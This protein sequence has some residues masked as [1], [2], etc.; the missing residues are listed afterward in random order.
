MAT[1]DSVAAF[2]SLLQRKAL[3]GAVLVADYATAAL[4]DICTSGGTLDAL[5]GYSSLGKLTSDGLTLSNS[6]E[7]QESRGWGD[8]A[9]PSRNDITSASS[10]M[11]FSAMESNAPVIDAFWGVDQTAVT[12][13][14]T[15]GSVVFDL[16]PLPVL[17]NKRVLGLFRDTNQSN[18]L[19][20][21][22]GVHYP[23]ANISQNG[24]QTL[25]NNDLTYP[26][27]AQ[28]LVDDVEGTPVRLMWGG[29][30]L[31]GVLADMGYTVAA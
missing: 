18:G 10:S 28:A 9:S 24:D 5:T 29:P 23:R 21:Y 11:A 16:P 30:G 27:T 26:M 31:A 14:A 12:A 13:S 25:V 22:L 4:T 3:V 17:R 1:F 6:Q 2:Q 15:T 20:I 8:T 19:D 7:K